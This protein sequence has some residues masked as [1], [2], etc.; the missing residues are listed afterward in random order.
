M[1]IRTADISVIKPGLALP[2]IVSDGKNS[3]EY[4]V[5]VEKCFCHGADDGVTCSSV[6]D[7]PPLKGQVKNA[8]HP[9]IYFLNLNVMNSSFVI[10]QVPLFIKC[11]VT[12]NTLF[13]FFSLTTR[14][15]T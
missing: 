12:F 14:G 10:V 4:N 3:E 13:S 2:I 11:H 9:M 7:S 8:V 15:I 6:A 5:N 1:S